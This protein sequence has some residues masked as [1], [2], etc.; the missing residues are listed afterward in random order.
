MSNPWLSLWLSAMNAWAGPMRVF[1]TEEMQR[2][3]AAMLDEWIQHVAQF[4]IAPW[5]GL[6]G[7]WTDGRR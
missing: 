7:W 5:A 2:Q 6:G 3:Q 1:W 4:W